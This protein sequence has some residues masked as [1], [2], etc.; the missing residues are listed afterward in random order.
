MS[1]LRGTYEIRGRTRQL[2]SQD[3]KA[4]IAEAFAGIGQFGEALVAV[5]EA[6]DGASQPGAEVWYVPEFLRIKGEILLQQAAD[7]SVSA[8][9]DCFKRASGMAREQA[10][11]CRTADRAELRAF[12]SHAEPAR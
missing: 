3:L 1:T 6:I 5:D 10:R 7:G 2:F 4:T 11:L 8:A 9:E 12:A